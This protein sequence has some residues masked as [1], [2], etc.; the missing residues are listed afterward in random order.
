MHFSALCCNRH[1]SWINPKP[2][3]HF[4]QNINFSNIARTKNNFLAK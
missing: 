1:I 4:N 2:T 3:L